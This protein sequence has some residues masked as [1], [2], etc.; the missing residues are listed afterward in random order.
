L[1]RILVENQKAI[2]GKQDR[3]RQEKEEE[4]KIA[5]YLIEKAKKEAEYQAELKRIKDEK[6][7]EIQRLRELQEKATDRQIEIDALRAKRATEIAERQAR[8]KERKEAERRAR[9]NGELKEARKYQSLQRQM[10]LEEQAIIER[11]EFNKIIQANKIEREIE[12]EIEHQKSARVYDHAGQLKKQIAINE[13]KQKQAKRV[14][15]E[16]GKQ[17]KDKLRNE[18]M[19]LENLKGQKIQELMQFDIPTKYTTEL[20][21]KRIII[22]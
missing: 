16:E 7:R 1:D 11:D 15:L 4:E 12:L 19:L 5:K 10:R 3:V 9:I 8:E 20:T 13:E 14:S 18:K 21:R 22:S 6:E 17:I 2:L